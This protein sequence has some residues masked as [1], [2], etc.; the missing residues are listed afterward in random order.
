MVGRSWHVEHETTQTKIFRTTAMYNKITFAIW[1][2][3]FPWET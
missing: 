1:W 2:L 3:K